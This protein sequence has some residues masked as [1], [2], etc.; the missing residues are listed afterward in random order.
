MRGAL[1]RQRTMAGNGHFTGLSPTHSPIYTAT[2][3]VHST[4]TAA[5]GLHSLDV[6]RGVVNAFAPTGLE[7][8]H[9]LL[10]PV[11]GLRVRRPHPPCVLTLFFCR[12]FPGIFSLE[13]SDA[14]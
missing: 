6:K 10:G 11:R 2:Y 13:F 5:P 4:Y 8:T 9:P 12:I 3:T 1:S 7:G 14:G